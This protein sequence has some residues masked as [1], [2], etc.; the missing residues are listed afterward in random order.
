MECLALYLAFSDITHGDLG[1][2][3]KSRLVDLPSLVRLVFSVGLGW[4]K[5]IF[6]KSVLLAM[7]PFSSSFS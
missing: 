2:I 7:F 5:V 6:C 4:S 1:C 3:V